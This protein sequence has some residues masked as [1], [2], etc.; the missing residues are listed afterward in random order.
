MTTFDFSDEEEEC[1]SQD[2]ADTV[3]Q[4]NIPNK[5]KRFLHSDH[6]LEV[7]DCQFKDHYFVKARIQASMNSK[8]YFTTVTIRKISGSV[9]DSTCLCKQR[10]L[11]R[12][13]HV[14][15]LLMHIT[16]Q[17]EER[18]YEGMYCLIKCLK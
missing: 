8:V 14:A 1:F 15:A 5:G 13:S 11:G 6:I 7:M 2:V 9:R 16:R 18:G 17:T 12:C 10:S 4:T 3:G